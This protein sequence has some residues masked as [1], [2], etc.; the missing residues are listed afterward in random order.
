MIPS[1]ATLAAALFVLAAPS[2]A[3]A[4]DAVR[5][6]RDI[7]PILSDACLRCHGPDAARRKADLRLD[8]KDGLLAAKGDA[9]AVVPGDPDASELIRRV[10]SDD[11]DERMPPPSSGKTL[12]AEQK[13]V[14]RRWVA[15]GAAWQGHWAFERPVAMPP[16]IPSRPDWVRN[17][18]D[19]FVLD[20]LD[21]E[22]LKPAPE[23]DPITLLR[24]VT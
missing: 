11:P 18:I 14:L 20:R 16:P 24:R 1:R 19:A 2:S 21:R 6:D 12:S 17:A 23:A 13:V 22:G 8:T 3:T 5:F 4:E 10:E 15:Q 9:R 7:R